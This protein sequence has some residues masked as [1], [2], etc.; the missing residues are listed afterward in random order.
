MFSWTF[1]EW[2]Q[3][4]MPQAWPSVRTTGS[5][6]EIKFLKRNKN[7]QEAGN[8]LPIGK[9][10]HLQ[11]L[12][13]QQYTT[14]SLR[15]LIPKPITCAESN[16]F[17]ASIT[18][19][20]S[21]KSQAQILPWWSAAPAGWAPHLGLGH[22]TNSWSRCV[23]RFGFL[24]GLALHALTAQVLKVYRNNTYNFL[25]KKQFPVKMWN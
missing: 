9:F 1:F 18:K 7:S 22:A 2:E 12:W 8:T 11:V 23:E 24:G 25:F 14:F 3:I 13:N 21:K 4:H 17:N 20:T 6:L 5:M 16:T 15:L 10:S 19:T